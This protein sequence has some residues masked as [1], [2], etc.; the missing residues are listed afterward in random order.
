VPQ[1]R[2][3]SVILFK[4]P[5]HLLLQITINK[6]TISFSSP[7]ASSVLPAGW[8][9]AAHGLAGARAV[10]Q[11]RAT[12]ACLHMCRSLLL[13]LHTHYCA[14]RSCIYAGAQNKRAKWLFFTAVPKTIFAQAVEI[15]SF[16]IRV[17]FVCGWKLEFSQLDIK[18][19][20]F[21]WTLHKIIRF[22]KKI[23]CLRK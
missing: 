23:S 1:R 12:A 20:V 15:S 11:K 9:A 8:M 22:C 7:S 19:L 13:L 4:V 2:A 3:E 18:L 14:P 16:Q 17:T 5:P 6:P 10:N 21:N